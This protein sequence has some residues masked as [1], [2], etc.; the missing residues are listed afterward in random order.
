MSKGVYPDIIGESVCAPELHDEVCVCRERVDPGFRQ[1][2]LVRK[3]LQV[4]R[5]DIDAG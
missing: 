1:L 3:S 2:A 4:R 5:N